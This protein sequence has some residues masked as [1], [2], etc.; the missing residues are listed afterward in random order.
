MVGR[1]MR[2]ATQF[3]SSNSEGVMR[4]S[5]DDRRLLRGAERGRLAT[6]VLML[7]MLFVMIPTIRGRPDMFTWL[8]NGTDKG[9][10]TS[11]PAKSQAS[12]P[13]G[14]K[15]AA[16]EESKS[17]PTAA[18]ASNPAKSEP[19][20]SEPARSTPPKAELVEPEA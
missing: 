18:P 7:I 5:R 11:P 8:T 9:Q 2:P 13:P 10:A 15:P 19:A 1:I 12:D 6:M 16:A 20:K 17:A 3:K 4:G 14:D